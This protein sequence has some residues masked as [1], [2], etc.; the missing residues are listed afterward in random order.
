M[1]VLSAVQKLFPLL[2]LLLVPAAQ[3]AVR[4][5]T[6]QHGAQTVGPM[7]IEVTT[8]AAAVDRVDFYVDG[9]LAGVAR[10]PPYRI[11]YDFGTELA[12]RTV[13]ARVWADAYKTS[14]SASVTTA[15]LTAGESITVDVVEVPLRLRSRQGVKASDLLVR[16]N[17]I[18]QTIRQV[19]FERPAAHFA[20]VV[21]RSL[22][23]GDGKLEATLAAVEAALGQLRPGDRSS[24]VLFNHTVARS[25]PIARGESLRALFREV[26]PSGG[27]SLRDA[28][29]SIA[30]TD[31]TYAITITDGGDRNSSLTDEV[32]LRKISGTKTVVEAIVLGSSRTNFLDRA[33]Q[34]TGGRVV[35]ATR[36]SV[37]TSLETLMADINSRY[38]LVYQSQ[39]TRRGWR[40]ITVTPK[41]RTVAI[42]NARKGYFAE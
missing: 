39:G 20:F 4:F 24:I 31:R 7:A 13:T 38:L 23:M 11:V 27:T 33:A 6:P 8:T 40:T 12:A 37:G 16:E 26:V 9:A 21:D 17:G 25:R 2:V 1:L 28:L 29:A 30:S 10:K 22:S 36:D 19:T 42:L 32:A 41:R 5:V 34:N 14:E 18:T 15:A 3:G 35:A